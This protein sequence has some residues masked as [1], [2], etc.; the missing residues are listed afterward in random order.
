MKPKLLIVDD[1]L[2]IISFMR[3]SL[4]DNGYHVLTAYNGEDALKLLKEEPDLIILDV[5]MPGMDGFE[6]CKLI[7]K[8]ISCPILFLSAKQTENDR[9]QGLLVG[10]DDYLVKP[11][12]MKELKIRIFAHLRREKRTSHQAY[13]RLHFGKLTIDLDSYQ[14]IH[15]SEEITFTTRE[16]EIIQYLAIHAGQV[17]TRDQIYEHV[18]GYDAEGEA[19]TITEHIKKVRAKLAK[20]DRNRI[21]ISTLWGVGYRWER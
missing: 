8:N 12:S 3:D 7:R 20:C 9:V 1:E 17:L 6:L 2:E 11:F 4:E 15:G 18:W 10:G 21:Y 19:S 14:V 5:M 13:N 16:F